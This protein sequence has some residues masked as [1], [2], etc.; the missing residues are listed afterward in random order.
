VLRQVWPVAFPVRFLGGVSFLLDTIHDRGKE[1][2]E[3]LHGIHGTVWRQQE[4]KPHESCP[5]VRHSTGTRDNQPGLD[6][7]ERF[8][9]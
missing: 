4:A 6:P 9:R 3:N 5:P 1:A 8:R 7:H 2:D